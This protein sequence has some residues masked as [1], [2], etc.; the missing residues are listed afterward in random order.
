MRMARWYA[1]MPADITTNQSEEGQ[2]ADPRRWTIAVLLGLGVLV[3]YFDRVNLSVSH[4]ALITTFGIRISRSGI[5]PAPTTGP[6]PCASSRSECCW[7]ASASA[8]SAA[9]AP[10]CGASLPSAQP[11]LPGLG[12]F[13]AA[14]FLLGRGR[15]AHL[16]RE[17]EGGRPLVS[18]EG[19][20]LFDRH[21]RF[22]R[23]VRQRHRR[24]SDRNRSAEGGVALELCRNR[25][26]QLRLFPVVLAGVPRPAGGPATE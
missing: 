4:A 26:H 22:G 21:L 17:R 16:S 5:S 11:S 19:T 7:T 1:T 6:T 15:G 12:G 13:F 10:F 8:A 9:S 14:R 2:A 18:A 3:N 20:Q 25:I 23:Q 24:A